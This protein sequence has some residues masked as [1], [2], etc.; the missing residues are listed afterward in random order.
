MDTAAAKGV[1]DLDTHFRA[2]AWQKAE[3]F[4]TDGV[5][6]PDQLKLT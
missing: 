1:F 6:T 2:L 5:V 3:G 4:A